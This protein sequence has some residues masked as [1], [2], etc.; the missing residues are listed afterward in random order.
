[1]IQD[2]GELNEF[3]K[4]NDPWGYFSNPDDLNRAEI[5]LS[6][7]PDIQYNNVLDIGC[8]QG[9]ITSKLQ[10]NNIY[11]V[12]ISEEAIKQAKKRNED[13]INFVQGSIFDLNKIFS[14]KFD[15]VV[16]TGVLYPQYIGHSSALIYKIIDDL[17][18]KG[19]FLIT[20]HI[21]EWYSCSFPYLKI[22]QF[23]Y[24][25]REYN[26]KLEIYGK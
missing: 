19:G 21:D 12:D 20:V 13:K 8:G 24:P 16:I 11:G 7:I 1:M 23:Y 4:T 2:L 17:L 18:I 22:K 26:H 15:L 5:L 10:G 9:F 3:H 6:E 25:Y 14:I